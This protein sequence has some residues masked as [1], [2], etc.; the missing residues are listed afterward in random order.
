MSQNNAT[1]SRTVVEKILSWTKTPLLL[2]AGPIIVLLPGIV[3]LSYDLLFHSS[4]G[5]TVWAL[6]RALYIWQILSRESTL[7]SLVCLALIDVS[8]AKR[9]VKL[10]LVTCILFA[11]TFLSF[12]LIASRSL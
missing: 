2:W 9:S 10:I 12:A 4:E 1:A 11:H 7:I 3:V 5:I 8:A 6:I